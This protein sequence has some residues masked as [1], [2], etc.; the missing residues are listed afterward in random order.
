MKKSAFLAVGVLLAVAGLSIGCA[1]KAQPEAAV[2]PQKVV[3]VLQHLNAPPENGN[4][5]VTVQTPQGPQNIQLAANATYEL[6]GKACT[7]EDIGNALV[8]GNTTYNCTVVLN[9]CEPGIV[10]QYL[11][12]FTIT[13]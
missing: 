11:S 8:A 9:P 1:G 2:S 10:A 12:V 13:Q 7:V 6:E 4:V 3:G 5:V